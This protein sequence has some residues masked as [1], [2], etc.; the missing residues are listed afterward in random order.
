MTFN[1]VLSWDGMEDV[2]MFMLAR[3]LLG[4]E[5]V[6]SGL[7]GIESVSSCGFLWAWGKKLWVSKFWR[8]GLCVYRSYK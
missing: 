4:F 1:S 3:G 7:T 5:S 2:F 6:T 8:K